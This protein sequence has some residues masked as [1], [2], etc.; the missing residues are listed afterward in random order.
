MKYIVVSDLH[1]STEEPLDDFYS[2]EE[3]AQMLN[4]FSRE[5]AVTL[6][7]NGDTIDFLQSSPEETDSLVN[8][9]IYCDSG[10]A[11]KILERVSKRHTV[12]F[13]ALTEFLRHN[14][15]RI[16]VL[17]GNHD[18]EFA[19]DLV[20]EKFKEILGREYQD[21][22]IFPEY[23][24]YIEDKGIYI[25]HGNQYDELNSF[26]NF[27]SPFQDIKK[28]HIELPFGSILVRVLW[29]RLERS[30]PFIDKIRPMTA[31][32]SL[33]IAQRPLFWAFRFD[34]FMDM[35]FYMAK[36]DFNPSN[37]IRKSLD[38]KRLTRP[39]QISASLTNLLH[40]GGMTLLTILFMVSF[41]FIKGLF[42]LD[43]SKKSS[44]SQAINFT[45]TSITDFSVL[46]GIG[47]G[48][49]IIGKIIYRILRKKPAIAYPSNIIF[50]IFIGASFGFLLYGVIKFFWIPI[51][52]ILLVAL[53]IDVHKSITKEISS[54]PEEIDKPFGE[55]IEAA[56]KLLKIP[57]LRYVI[58]GHTH[59]PRFLMV[60]ELK[61]LIN[62]G[63]WIYNL[64][65]YSLENRNFMQTFVLIDKDS[66]S[67]NVFYGL[68]GYNTLKSVQLRQQ[69]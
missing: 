22:I 66:I 6:I 38:E 28:K 25:E 36:R 11:V 69:T 26:S 17:K 42:F 27:Q 49:Y 43:V 14:E 7:F 50:R 35:F 37:L 57:E 19:F 5:E 56:K 62:S 39:E 15:N 48:L 4:I 29:N 13:G 45:F 20:Q 53:V 18:A 16:V 31:S 65:L 33:A 55:E 23:G 3:F 52:I 12:F 58:F 34:Y 21:R 54:Q 59:F 41:F 67:L 9:S 32:I 46:I 63:T 44:L 40:F 24:Y 51:V 30:F 2:D 47:V 10:S 1:L 61:Y 60:D 64:D 8:D 68:K